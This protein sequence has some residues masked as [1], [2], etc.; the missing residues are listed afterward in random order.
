M[1][2]L[3]TGASGRLGSALVA[4]LMSEGRH[5]V[6]GW[7]GSTSSRRG[8]ESPRP[9]DLTD[10]RAVAAALRNLDPDGVIHAAAISSADAVIRDPVRARAVNVEATRLLAEWANSQGR[11]LVFT[12][13]DL[14]FDG[15]RSCYAEDD[16]ANPIMAYGR[17]KHEAE[18]HVLAAPGGLVARLSLLYGPTPAARPDFFAAAMNAMR[19][20]EPCA[21]FED[22]FRT[23]LDYR[24]AARIL[25]QLVDADAVGLVHVGGRERLSRFELIRRAAA[26]A[27]IDPNLVRP[28]RRADLELSEP[29]PA[30]VSLDTTRLARLVAD[31]RRPTVEDV[32]TE[33]SRA[34]SSILD[35]HDS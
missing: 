26:T 21:F 13:T 34:A 22:E 20:G 5:Q 10:Q 25:V 4:R 27:G 33:W 8:P 30:D 17:S 12:S 11:R 2:I 24:S 32:A 15:T 28:N 35:R 6:M 16:R 1:R 29:R 14:V 23:P 31:L 7:S 19:R 3:V 18:S 9:V